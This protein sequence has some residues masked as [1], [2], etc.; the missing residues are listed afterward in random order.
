MLGTQR[1][2]GISSLQ[3]IKSYQDLVLVSLL[4]VA[5]LEQGSG[6]DNLQMALPT[7]TLPCGSVI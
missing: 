4:W 2:C 7:S 1:G 5:L 6:P 3:I